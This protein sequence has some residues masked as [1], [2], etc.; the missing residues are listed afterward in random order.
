MKW[1]VL[2]RI[3]GLGGFTFVFLSAFTPLPNVLIRHL[4]VFSEPESTQGI[5]VLGGGLEPSGLLNDKSLRSAIHGI[6][7]YREGLAPVLVFLGEP[8]ERGVVEAEVRTRLARTLGVPRE[9]ILTETKAK[10]T[11]EEAFYVATLLRPMGVRTILLVTDSLH[12]SRAR[13]V[14]Q[15]AGLEVH[16]AP[17]GVPSVLV[18]GPEGRLQAMRLILRELIARFY[19][20]LAVY[21]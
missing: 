21:S 16:P 20:W 8:N 4:A 2:L 11:Q 17:V 5:V 12:M 3:L 14:F 1:R 18:S 6:T 15:Q 19:Y 7:L 9:Q 10:T 13:T